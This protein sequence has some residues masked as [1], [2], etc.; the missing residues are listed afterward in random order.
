MI[1]DL[2]RRSAAEVFE[3]HLRLAG[4]HHFEEDRLRRYVA[5]SRTPQATCIA[6]PRMATLELFAELGTQVKTS[7]SDIA[8]FNDSGAQL[9]PYL[10]ISE[11]R[12]R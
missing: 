4:E 1:D 9:S 12:L 11:R 6:P 3:D 2:R 7:S 5:F 8:P 10:T